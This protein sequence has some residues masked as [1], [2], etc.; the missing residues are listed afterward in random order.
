MNEQEFKGLLGES[1]TEL[2][3]NN[4]I[5]IYKKVIRDVK[6]PTEN[7]KTTQIDNILIT[8]KGI[9]VIENKNWNAIVKND[10]NGNWYEISGGKRIDLNQNPIKQNKY[11]IDNLKKVLKKENDNLFFSIV[12]LGY[13]ATKDLDIDEEKENVKIIHIYEITNTIINILL[14]TEEI[15]LSHEE[16]DQIYLK[17]KQYDL[18]QA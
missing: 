11:H 13:N 7:G 12:V 18:V 2:L 1:L 17:L 9:F 16:I 3:I 10:P 5:D 8:T 4:Q 15:L 14:S 6:I